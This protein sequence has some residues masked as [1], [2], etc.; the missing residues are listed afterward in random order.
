[1]GQASGSFTHYGW[2][3]AGICL[4]G[5][6]MVSYAQ[7]V[8]EVARLT[9]SDPGAFDRFGGAVAISGDTALIG[10]FWDNDNGA[11]SGSAYVFRFDGR[12]WLQQQKLL[13]TDGQANDLFGYAV[14][15]SADKALVGAIGDATAAGAVYFFRR[16]DGRGWVEEQKLLASD[17]AEQDLFGISVAALGITRTLGALL[18]LLVVTGFFQV[19]LTATT[20]TMLQSLVRDELRGRVMAVYALAFLGLLPFGTLV[21][22]IVAERWGAASWLTGSGL[23]CTGLALIAPRTSPSLRAI[24]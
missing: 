6:P 11:D 4:L 14:A 2:A 5:A 1:M 18:P 23:I 20:N 8:C 9:A 7:S 21:A 12:T 10:A 13:A 19:V 15:I 16:I 24:G 17:G 22:G 3:M